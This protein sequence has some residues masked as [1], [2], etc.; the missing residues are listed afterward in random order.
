VLLYIYLTKIYLNNGNWK[1]LEDI[2][3][4]VYYANIYNE[5]VYDDR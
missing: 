4:A 3:E 1:S 5:V 2:D